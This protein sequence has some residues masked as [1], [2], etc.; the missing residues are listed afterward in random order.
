MANYR[1]KRPQ[2]Q[3]NR[4]LFLVP[5]LI[6]VKKI[7]SSGEPKTGVLVHVVNLRGY[8]LDRLVVDYDTGE[9]VTEMHDGDRIVRGS[10]VEYLQQFREWK[11][12][13][14]YKGNLSEIKSWMKDLTPNEK[15]ILFTVS[16]YVGYEDCCLK[17]GNGEMVT[18]D[19]IVELSG[20]SRGAVSATI[21]SL[22]GKD[23]ICRN[24]N[25][26]ERQY[27]VNPWLFCKGN[28]INRVLQTMFRNY[29]V[30]VCG[31]IKWKHI[32]G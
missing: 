19:H 32:K 26:K 23:I 6:A 5:Q 18:F 28:R 15:A 10:S 7:S 2:I 24:K 13:H 30:R 8:K 9:V 29:G 27:F 16:P 1:I 11:I 25:S 3:E 4:L 20:L 21:N 14:F 12:E 17:H 31:G 22:I